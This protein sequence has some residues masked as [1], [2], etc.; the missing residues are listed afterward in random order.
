MKMLILNHVVNEN[1]VQVVSS[2]CK[3][4]FSSTLGRFAKKSVLVGAKIAVD[5]RIYDHR[6][7]EIELS[8]RA[9]L[10]QVRVQEMRPRI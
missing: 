6:L 5:G 10:L 4:S 9:I 7:K 2:L 1:E 8:Y 3:L